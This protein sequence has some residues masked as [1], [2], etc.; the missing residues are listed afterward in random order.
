MSRRARRAT[1]PTQP[2]RPMPR[3]GDKFWTWPIEVQRE[4][5]AYVDETPS[6]EARR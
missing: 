4:V 5:L 2:V 6:P 3:N 1:E